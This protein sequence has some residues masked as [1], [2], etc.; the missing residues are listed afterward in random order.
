MEETALEH[1]KKCLLSVSCNVITEAPTALGGGWSHIINR[2]FEDKTVL[3]CSETSFPPTSPQEPT[4]QS[5]RLYQINL[6]EGRNVKN[7]PLHYHTMED[8][9]EVAR[10]RPCKNEE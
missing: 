5:W 9:L 2:R 6:M 7:T 4:P 10:A 1:L 8:V 3:Q